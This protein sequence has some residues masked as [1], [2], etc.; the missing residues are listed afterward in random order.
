[1]AC[2]LSLHGK[3][4]QQTAQCGEVGVDLG[5]ERH[6]LTLNVILQRRDDLLEEL[7]GHQGAPARV[8]LT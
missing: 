2:D 3:V 8:L 7:G 5:E 1:M 4:V 6:L